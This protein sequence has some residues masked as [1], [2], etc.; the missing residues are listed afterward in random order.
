MKALSTIII[1]LTSVIA[2]AQKDTSSKYH[3]V[4]VGGKAYGV[5]VTVFW[6][7][8]AIRVIHEQKG[9]SD[10]TWLGREDNDWNTKLPRNVDSSKFIYMFLPRDYRPSTMMKIAVNFNC[11][12]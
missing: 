3:D 11:P 4:Y 9:K 6:K 8:N 10:T 1:L 2:Y 12:Q 5:S 7:Q